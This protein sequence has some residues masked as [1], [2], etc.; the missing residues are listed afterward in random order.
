MT[1]VS[2]RARA[3]WHMLNLAWRAQPT[4]FVGMVAVTTFQGAVP[5]VTAW[6]TKLVFDLLVLGLTEDF[7]GVLMPRLLYILTA[8]AILTVIS[9]MMGPVN[10]YISAEMSRRLTVTIQTDIYRTIGGFVGIAHFETPAFHDTFRIASQK[11]QQLPVQTLYACT[12]LF[13]HAVTLVGFLGILVTFSPLLAALV[14]LATLPQLYARLKI[15]HQRFG[16][17]SGFSPDERRIYYFGVI[18]SSLSTSKEVRLFGLVDHYL[19]A[20]IETYHRL[21]QSQRQQERQ[22]LRWQL[23][24]ELLTTF[25]SSAAF[26]AVVLQAFAG[27]ISLGEVTL[28]ASAVRSIQGALTGG[29]SAFSALNEQALFFSHYQQLKALPQPVTFPVK[30]RCVKA[31]ASGLELRDVWFRYN[32]DHPWVLQ[33]VSL[34]IPLGQRLALVGLNGAGKTTLVKLLT[35]LYD[36]T[37]GAILW[38]GVDIR[39]LDPIALRRRIGVI[40][41]DF[42]RYEATAQEN[43]G[44]GNVQYIEDTSRIR[45]AA[46]KAGVHTLIETLPH[47]YQTML[48][49]LFSENGEGTD[50]SG[51]EWQKIA[52]ARMFMREADF[53]ILDEPTA[54]LDAQAEYQTYA[55]FTELVSGRT[56]LIISHRFSTVRM[57]DRIAVLENGR[58]SECGSHADLLSQNGAYAQL[59]RFQADQYI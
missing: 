27:R 16:L 50:L 28:Y 14:G 23:F 47:G 36:P 46:E 8:Q 9:Q 18:L 32:K 34:S 30:P 31:L 24:L 22:E 59:Y 26:V 54:A 44:L 4:I 11:A 39:E 45:G 57:A 10:A 43:I 48:S 21:H 7:T 35:R 40:F 58:I 20:L 25:V 52:L 38:D 56:S 19:N 33:G 2:H 53:L 49:R 37:E 55:Y 12:S 13:Q 1:Q 6:F 51:G 17:A 29:I 15:G 5:L 41:Q 42:V 3:V